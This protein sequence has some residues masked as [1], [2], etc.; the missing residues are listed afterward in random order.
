MVKE[1]S[2]RVG[3]LEDKVDT[4][5]NSQSSSTSAE[6]KKRIPSQLTVSDSLNEE[7]KK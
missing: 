2:Q 4:I 3:T 5:A 6:E 7:F 1:V